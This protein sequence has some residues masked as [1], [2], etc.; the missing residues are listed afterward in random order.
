MKKNK[1]FIV[2]V[3]LALA[4]ASFAQSAKKTPPPADKIYTPE[5]LRINWPGKNAAPPAEDP[6][7][8]GD[9]NYRTLP[10]FAHSQQAAALK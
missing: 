2:P 7:G 4:T 9:V 8:L 5:Q 6:F 10:T 3:L 1:L